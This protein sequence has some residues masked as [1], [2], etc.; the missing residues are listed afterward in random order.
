MK[1]HFRISGMLLLI[2]LAAASAVGS[3]SAQETPEFSLE[4]VAGDVYCLYGAGGNIGILKTGEGLLLVDAQY[5]RTAETALA[6]IRELSDQPV[7][8]LINTHYHGDHTDGNSILGKGAVIMAHVNCRESFLRG[9]GPEE[10]PEAKGAPGKTFEMEDVVEM[11]G[12]RIRLRHF[13]PGHTAG[14]TVV[15]FEK[16]GVIHTGDLFFHGLPPYIDVEDGS[17]TGN[18]VRTIGRLAERYPDFML[19]PGHGRVATMR[20]WVGFAEYLKFLRARV[21]AA[22]DEGKTREQ[23]VASIDTTRFADIGDQGEFLTK[24]KNVGWIYDEM[25]RK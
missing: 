11:G 8:F 6:R 5:S 4:K 3:P 12:E 16:A 10:S 17:D 20:D 23:A 2:G 21:K 9:L 25:T 15:V 1:R 22:I 24:S 18:W 13:G 14:D 19:I 7:R